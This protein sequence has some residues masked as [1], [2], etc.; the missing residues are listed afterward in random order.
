MRFYIIKEVTNTLDNQTAQTNQTA[1]SD[2]ANQSN[3]A[4]QSILASQPN[5]TNLT[6]QPT[7]QSQPGDV[8]VQDNPTNTNTTNLPQLT[9]L[10]D[11][12]TGLRNAGNFPNNENNTPVNLA[13]SDPLATLMGLVKGDDGKLDQLKVKEIFVV[14][15]S[16][17]SNKSL[18]KMVDIYK[19]QGKTDP[20]VLNIIL[21]LDEAVEKEEITE[22]LFIDLDKTNGW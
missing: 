20:E 10:A 4:N 2:Q 15:R 19:S 6:S 8:G 18:R 1:Q 11:Q 16:K 9:Q 5:L 21:G 3:L 14:T 12:E 7:Q 13:S 17:I 22:D